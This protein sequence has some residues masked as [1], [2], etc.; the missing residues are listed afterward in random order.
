MEEAILED[1]IGSHVKLVLDTL[2][3]HVAKTRRMIIFSQILYCATV[4]SLC[5]NGLRFLFAPFDG[6]FGIALLF[7]TICSYMVSLEIKSRTTLRKRVMDDYERCIGMAEARY[8]G[9]STLEEARDVS[10]KIRDE[11]KK[12]EHNFYLPET[13][14]SYV[15]WV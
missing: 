13:Y 2:R 7:A 6:I 14:Y 15:T 11:L 4:T 12:L 8:D 10:R 3:L 9:V 5:V 1:P